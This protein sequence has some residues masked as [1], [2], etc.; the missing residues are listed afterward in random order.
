MIDALVILVGLGEGLVVGSA[1]VSFIVAIGVVDQL[2]RLTGT[3]ARGGAYEAAIA[4]GATAAALDEAH[5][6]R[7]H[8]SAP[9][10][11]AVALGMGVF[12]GLVAAGLTEVIDVLPVLSRR[13][14]LRRGLRWLVWALVAGKTLGTVLWWA[15]PSLWGRPPA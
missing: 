4:F 5:P 10:V 2:S 3:P 1:F 11:A 13:L 12:L 9:V 14:G 7:L 15:I 8:L 6:L